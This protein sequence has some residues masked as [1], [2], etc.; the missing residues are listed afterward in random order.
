M[1]IRHEALDR[2]KDILGRTSY[3]YKP[4]ASYAYTPRACAKFLE[5]ARI[6]KGFT[7]KVSEELE[8]KR[9]RKMKEFEPKELV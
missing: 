9:R 3:N 8:E 1:T 2:V 5:I 7:E 4:S 6:L